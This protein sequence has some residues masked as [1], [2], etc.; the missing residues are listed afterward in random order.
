MRLNP[1]ARQPLF[2]LNF[3]VRELQLP[4]LNSFLLAYAN[5]DV[6]KGTFE[7]Y[8]EINAKDGAYDGYVKPLLHDLDFK[9]A[10]DEDKNFADRV[11]ETVV[12]AVS[13]VFKNDEQDQVATKAPFAGNFADNDLDIWTTIVNLLRNAFVQ[14]IRGGLEGET[15]TS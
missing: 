8:S 5:A 14:A 13:S 10:S 3:E 9:T 15:P 1:I 12:S 2:A 11:K 6:S 4:P 7:L